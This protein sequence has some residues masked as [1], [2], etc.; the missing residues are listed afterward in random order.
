M[1][2]NKEQLHDLIELSLMCTL[3]KCKGYVKATISSTEFEARME[4]TDYIRSVEVIV[5]HDG[6]MKVSTVDTM[7]RHHADVEKSY[8]YESYKDTAYIS[9]VVLEKW[10]ELK[11]ASS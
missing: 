7:Q 8:Y 9:E 1:K 4:L 3:K 10:R 11:C 2:M 5:M 6:I